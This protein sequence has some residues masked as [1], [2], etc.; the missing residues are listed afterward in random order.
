[1]DQEKLRL[2]ELQLEEKD[3]II[4]RLEAALQGEAREWTCCSCCLLTAV[5]FTARSD[6]TSKELNKKVQVLVLTLQANE[7][8]GSQVSEQ[9]AII[10]SLQNEQSKSHSVNLAPLE[11][12]RM[13]AEQL[14]MAISIIEPKI[15]ILDSQL[16]EISTLAQENKKHY[17]N[18]QIRESFMRNEHEAIRHFLSQRENIIRQQS[19]EL[20]QLRTVC[21]E[22]DAKIEG[23]LGRGKAHVADRS[24]VF[25]DG[26]EAQQPQGEV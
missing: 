24:L 26:F 7:S 22:R 25:R 20:F 11:E 13:E 21:N 12:M 4:R 23:G 8:F 14:Q 6:Q 10:K 19:N 16:A 3:E 1:M 2:H 9:E 17:C 5:C 15:H 18:L